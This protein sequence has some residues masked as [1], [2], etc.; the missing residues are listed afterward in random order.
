MPVSPCQQCGG[1]PSGWR[2][3]RGAR[4]ARCRDAPSP[5]MAG[6]PSR[7]NAGTGCFRD[8]YGV[9]QADRAHRRP[10]TTC[11]AW[12]RQLPGGVG[13]TVQGTQHRRP[14]R[15]GLHVGADGSTDRAS[16]VHAVCVCDMAATRPAGARPWQASEK[17]LRSK[18][19]PQRSPAMQQQCGGVDAGRSP[20]N[21]P[22]RFQASRTAAAGKGGGLSGKGPGK[23]GAPRGK[24]CLK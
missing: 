3:R 14:A 4:R 11:E 8:G 6:R 5:P 17:K 7:C 19:A 9:S 20:V 15:A 24:G 1:R 23:P 18:R 2:V 22:S 21:T 12:V 13:K 16:R 10:A